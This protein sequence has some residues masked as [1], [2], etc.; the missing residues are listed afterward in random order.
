MTICFPGLSHRCTELVS[1]THHGNQAKGGWIER[2]REKER[3]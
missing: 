3:K 1:C 2:K